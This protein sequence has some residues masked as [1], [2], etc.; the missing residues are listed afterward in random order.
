MLSIRSVQRGYRKDKE[1]RLSL[2]S[3]CLGAEES[4]DGIE[5]SQLVERLTVKKRFY[6]CC[7]Y[8][9]TGIISTVLTT[10]TRKRL[11]KAS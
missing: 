4:R 6:E 11:V 9:E 1:D 5:A 2:L 3:F 8:S 7:G 10:V